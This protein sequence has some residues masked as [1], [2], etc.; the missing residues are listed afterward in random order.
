MPSAYAPTL[1]SLQSLQSQFKNLSDFSKEDVKKATLDILP[2]AGLGTP[3]LTHTDT[4][5]CAVLPSKTKNCVVFINKPEDEPWMTLLRTVS[6]Q[7][8]LMLSQFFTRDTGLTIAAIFGSDY[9]EAYHSAI[10]KKVLRKN[11]TLEAAGGMTVKTAWSCVA[12]DLLY[13]RLTGQ[14]FMDAMENAETDLLRCLYAKK[15]Q[16][17]F[18]QA[19]MSQNLLK[20]IFPKA[21]VI[22]S[23][24]S[25]E[26][27]TGMD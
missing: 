13:W 17:A 23:V 27:A 3:T 7:V 20:S 11:A 9:W 15:G 21:K 22:L 18:H 25:N 19:E 8:L 16:I 24:V 12:G 26:T 10:T 6:P 4:G 14:L 2:Y 5:L 1:Q